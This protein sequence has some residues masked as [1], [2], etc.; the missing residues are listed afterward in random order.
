MAWIT[1]GSRKTE[2]RACERRMIDVSKMYLCKFHNID[3]Q[4]NNID[5]DI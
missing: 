3:E 5:A 1:K 2:R 4:D